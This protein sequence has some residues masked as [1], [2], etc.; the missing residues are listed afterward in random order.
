MKN[1]L[2]NILFVVTN[3]E[4][5][6]NEIK[7]GVYFEEFAVPY[8]N[9][10]KAGFRIDVASIKG[11]DCPID[12][13][14]LKCSNPNE[15]D[16]CAKYLK[17][18]KKLSEIDKTNYNILFFPGGHGPM[19]DIA[20]NSTVKEFVE[21]FCRQNKIIGA[22]CH[23]VCALLGGMDE[24]REYILKNKKVT[25]FTNQEEEIAKMTEFMP[26]LLQD[27]IIEEGGIF[28]EEKPFSSHIEHDWNIVT[29]QN[30]NSSYL[31]ADKIIELSK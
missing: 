4:K 19:F 6:N 14:S 23:G 8:L 7:T 9:F 28:I 24:N 21:D 16:S 17:N 27:K 31:I 30:Q 1:I 15:W 11:G 3:T 20:Y 22:I 10:Q 2:E 29:G 18:T 25:G 13:S 12:E 26:F 5:I